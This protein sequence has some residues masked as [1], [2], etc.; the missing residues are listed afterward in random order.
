MFLL[1]PYLPLNLLSIFALY[2]LSYISNAMLQFFDIN[3]V[4]QDLIADLDN[5]KF[6]KAITNY[7][8]N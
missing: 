3:Q 8:S 5:L 4:Q 7:L 1:A 2:K 6:K